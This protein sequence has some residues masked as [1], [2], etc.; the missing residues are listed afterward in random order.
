M[1][2][3]NK[4]NVVAYGIG[5]KTSRGPK[6]I[7]N[8]IK[9]LLG[10]Q[11]LLVFVSSKVSAA[12][13][14]EED[15]IPKEIQGVETDVIE[16][17]EIVPV[18]EFR[19]KHRPLIGGV[20]ACNAKGSA[21]TSG[22][23][24]WK[25]DKPHALMNYH[26]S[27]GTDWGSNIGEPVINPSPIDGGGDV[28]GHASEFVPLEEGICDAGLVKLSVEMEDRVPVIGNYETEVQEIKVGQELHK[29]GRTTGYTKG[30]VLA[31]NV[32]SMVNYRQPDGTKKTIT[33]YNQVF[34]ENNGL[35]FINGGDSSSI[36]FY[37]KSPV[38]QIY[39]AS[40]VVGVITPLKKVLDRLN[41]S[42]VPQT[43]YVALG[44]W[45]SINGLEITTK[46]RT[47]LRSS[48]GLGDNRIRVL[49]RN[50]KLE[51]KEFA[52]IADGYYW[53]KVV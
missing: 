39:A 12:S 6:R 52:G 4:K 34:T 41:V 45:L 7:I 26:C 49:P 50:T 31:T 37:G 36:A 46:E 2:L 19:A 10:I 53:L 24:V 28:I 18:S 47:N 5:Y 15:L 33:F 14:S 3:L 22:I 1:N 35:S 32:V 16:V 13:L 43:A 29:S 20:S 30:R 42:L 44:N 11:S 23:R 17:G 21:C 9:R 51:I 40:P 8:L 27:I 25:G 48:I 38:G